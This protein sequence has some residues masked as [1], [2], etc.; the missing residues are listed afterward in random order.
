MKINHIYTHSDLK[1]ALKIEE[2]VDNRMVCSVMVDKKFSNIHSTLHG[3]AYA[4]LA[5]ENKI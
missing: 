4:Y 1:A 3:G 2:L 5:G